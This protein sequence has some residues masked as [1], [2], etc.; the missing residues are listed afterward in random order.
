MRVIIAGSRGIQD[1]EVV[2]AALADAYLFIGIEPT[3]VLSGTAKGVDRLGEQW[4]ALRN[5]PCE[6]YPAP[7]HK[8]PKTAGRMR[9]VQM[10]R[11]ADALVAVWDGSSTGTKHMIDWMQEAGKTVWVHEEKPPPSGS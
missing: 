7:W 3:V 1:L 4:A 2:A 5:I 11:K 9:N 8:Y 10:G 6:H